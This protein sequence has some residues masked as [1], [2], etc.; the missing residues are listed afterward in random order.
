MAKL[1][2]ATHNQGK[3]REFRELLADNVPSLDVEK[4]VISAADLD[5]QE[6]VEDGLSFEENA[7]IKARAIAAETSLPVIADDSGLEVDVLNGMPGIFSARWAGEHGGDH[8]SLL[9]GQIADV[10]PEHR[11]GRFHCCAVLV[12]PAGDETVVHGTMEGTLTTEPR[13]NNGFGYDPIMVPAG[14]SKTCAELTADE[15]NAISH[16]GNAMKQLLPYIRA[17]FPQKK[18]L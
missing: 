4:D 12:T 6:P 10:K 14:Y 1:L 15:K 3:V 7:L 13:G 2:L 18:N 8:V 11:G 5:V 17:I 16:R 9:L